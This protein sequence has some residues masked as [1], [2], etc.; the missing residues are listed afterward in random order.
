MALVDG[1]VRPFITIEFDQETR[2]DIPAGPADYDRIAEGL[3]VWVGSARDGSG[4]TG[5]V[6]D[7][8]V[9][10]CGE[11]V[12][13]DIYGKLLD[14]LTGGEDFDGEALAQYMMPAVLAIADAWVEQARAVKAMRSRRFAH[15]LGG[16]QDAI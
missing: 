3:P 1:L 13:M 5:Y 8:L 15:Y 4:G 12:G 14:Y 6:M 11:D 2:W 7:S 9:F 16:P 10:L